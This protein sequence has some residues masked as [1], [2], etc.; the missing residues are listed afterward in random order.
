VKTRI[1]FAQNGATHQI[2]AAA[3]R[4]PAVQ[5]GHDARL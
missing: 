1:G 2:L 3:V 5:V 4:D